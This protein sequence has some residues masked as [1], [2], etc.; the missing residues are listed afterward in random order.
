MLD[1]L[2]GLSFD[3]YDDDEEGAQL[4]FQEGQKNI[5]GFALMTARDRILAPT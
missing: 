5:L 2:W 1:N 4:C 3:K